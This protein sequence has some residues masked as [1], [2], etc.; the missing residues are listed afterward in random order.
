MNVH[1][2]YM[3]VHIVFMNVRFHFSLS[4]FSQ[5]SGKTS[6]VISSYYQ[7]VAY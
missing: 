4:Y 1:I 6:L 3:N 7:L 2:V 5:S